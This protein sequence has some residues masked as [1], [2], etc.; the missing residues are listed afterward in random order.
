MHKYIQK[1][2]PT[3]ISVLIRGLYLILCQATFILLFA[4]LSRELLPSELL[5]RRCTAMLE[6]TAMS[7]VILIVG[8]ML[9]DLTL[10]KDERH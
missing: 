10:V 5:A 1:F 8:A 6:Y 2:S 7:L 4:N 3:P 9:L